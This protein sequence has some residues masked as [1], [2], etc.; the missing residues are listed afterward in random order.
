MFFNSVR[1]LL[2]IK[3]PRAYQGRTKG[4]APILS[5]TNFLDCGLL[6]QRWPYRSHPVSTH[7]KSTRFWDFI[8]I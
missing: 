2:A 3:N 8:R 1:S 7:K 5:Q 4:L 6:G